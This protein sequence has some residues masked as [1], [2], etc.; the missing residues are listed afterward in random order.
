MFNLETRPCGLRLFTGGTLSPASTRAMYEKSSKYTTPKRQVMLT[1]ER[2]GFT[3][4]AGS[5]SY[6]F[7]QGQVRTTLGLNDIPLMGNFLRLG[8]LP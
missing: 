8:I 5:A 7:I 4:S 2:D 3:V 1:V 6:I